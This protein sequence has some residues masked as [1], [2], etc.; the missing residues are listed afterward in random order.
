MKLYTYIHYGMGQFGLSVTETLVRVYLLIF[1]TENYPI[2]ASMAG[3]AAALGVIWDAATDPLMGW[4]SD[5]TKSKWGPR[6]PYFIPG[7]IV[8]G[9]AITLLFAPPEFNSSWSCFAYLLCNYVLLNTGMTLFS[10]PYAALGADLSEDS[11]IRTNLMGGKFI[12]ANLGMVIG[13]ALPSWI[14]WSQNG[15]PAAARASG[16]I[17]VVCCIWVLLGLRQLVTP[18]I[19]KH[20]HRFNLL[21]IWRNR[22]FILLATAY[23][24]ATIGLTTDVSLAVYYYKYRI[25][26]GE[27]IVPNLIAWFILIF[28]LSIPLWIWLAKSFEKKNLLVIGALGVGCVTSLTYPF[29]PKLLVYPQYIVATLCG[30]FVGCLVL[31][32]ALMIEYIDLDEVFTRRNRAGIYFGIWKFLE[33]SSR[34]AA[35]LF[36]GFALDA[37]GWSKHIQSDDTFGIALL[38]GPGVGVYYLIAAVITGWIRFGPDKRRQVERIL[39]KL[40]SPKASRLVV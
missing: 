17:C 1:Y 9:V 13:A 12:L 8:M 32:D 38:Y 18:T 20:S 10:V 33:K 23:S 22:P 14:G 7:S 3:T 15:I 25:Q 31:M 40:K 29:M 27:Q 2:S 16:I 24:L 37:V 35:L 5:H 39:K 4:I 28:S 21:G 11:A 30:L 26:V 36:V 6:L 34:A 19:P